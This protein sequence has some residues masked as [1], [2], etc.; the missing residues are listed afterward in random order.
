MRGWVSGI[1]VTEIWV[2]LV[3][4]DL[5]SETVSSSKCSRS[6]N[7]GRGFPVSAFIGKWPSL[8]GF[9]KADSGCQ[10][11]STTGTCVI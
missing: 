6:P 10:G 7:Q 5:E 9:G 4:L 1:C 3:S 8:F 11:Q 2:S